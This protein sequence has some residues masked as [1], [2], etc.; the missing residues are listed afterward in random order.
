VPGVRSGER[1]GRRALHDHQQLGRSGSRSAVSPCPTGSGRTV[2]AHSGA[3]RT[4]LGAPTPCPARSVSHGASGS[5][6]R[7]TSSAARVNVRAAGPQFAR[8]GACQVAGPR[9]GDGPGS[10]R[11]R[12]W[13]PGDWRSG[14]SLSLYHEQGS[15]GGPSSPC[16]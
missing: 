10:L 16:S 4:R 12:G 3:G 11:V 13:P 5:L 15:G 2:V 8:R 1:Q 14:P 6:G 7:S 9:R